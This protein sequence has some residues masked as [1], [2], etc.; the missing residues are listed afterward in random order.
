[1][2]GLPFNTKLNI[3]TRS[4]LI[5]SQDYIDELKRLN[6]NVGIIYSSKDDDLNR[7]NEPGAPSYNRRA[8]AVKNLVDAGIKAKLVEHTIKTKKGIKYD[9]VRI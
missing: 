8:Y 7:L 9:K 4:D 6:V 3:Y 1:M 5:A 2:R